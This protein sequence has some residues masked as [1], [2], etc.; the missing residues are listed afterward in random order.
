M[1]YLKSLKTAYEI[2]FNKAQENILDYDQA[3]VYER[4]INAFKRFDEFHIENGLSKLFKSNG[5]TPEALLD[6][7]SN[8]YVP[9]KD[10]KGLYIE[11]KDMDTLVRFAAYVGG[12]EKAN[13]VKGL[14]QYKTL[15]P[16][17]LELFLDAMV[18]ELR[19]YDKTDSRTYNGRLIGS[20]F[21]I[22]DIRDILYRGGYNSSSVNSDASSVK[23]L[24]RFC[25]IITT[26]A[27]DRGVM[28][29]KPDAVRMIRASVL[30]HK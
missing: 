16:I 8:E 4:G 25:G 19:V 24:L 9:T 17:P 26:D 1:T 23:T 28:S 13:K 29:V 7:A 3:R 22:E 6:M 20:K 15:L 30:K 21:H 14:R 2:K 10:D 27:Y 12:A 11:A 5:V 18:E